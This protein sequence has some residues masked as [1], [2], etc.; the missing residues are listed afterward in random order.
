MLI[1]FLGVGMTSDMYN[2]YSDPTTQTVPEPID[3]SHRGGFASPA[4]PTTLRNADA[5][6]NIKPSKYDLS[7]TAGNR[8]TFFDRTFSKLQKGSLRGSIFNLVSTALGGGV[9]ALSYVF[10]LS[11][12]AMGLILLLV[13]FSGSCLSNLIFAR[14]AC[15]NGLSNI[16]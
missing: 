5:D 6:I 11:G 12:W 8:R 14:M 4:S 7:P 9:L 13:G 1:I 2:S 15:E 16:D 3:M 10:V